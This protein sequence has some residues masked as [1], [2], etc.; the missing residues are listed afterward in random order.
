MTITID[1]YTVR[2]MAFFKDKTKVSPINCIITKTTLIFIVDKGTIKKAIGRGAVNIKSLRH[3][4]KK[5]IKVFERAENIDELVKNFIYPINLN[6]TKLYRRVLSILLSE[7]EDRGRLLGNGQKTIRQL[8]EVLKIY[9]PD[10][11]DVQ[12]L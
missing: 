11:R 9:H 10:I 12:L 8:K 3:A 6:S 5:D 2:T 4:F 7:P 1:N